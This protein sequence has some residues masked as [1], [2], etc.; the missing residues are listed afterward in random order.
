MDLG[1]EIHVGYGMSE[2]CPVMTAATPMERML[3]WENE[4]YLDVIPKTSVGKLDKKV[5]RKTYDK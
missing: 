3:D 4:K 2:T 1:I 5:L